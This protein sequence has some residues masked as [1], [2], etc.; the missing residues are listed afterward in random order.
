MYAVTLS[1]KL[2]PLT[3][4]Q[5]SLNIE[6]RDRQ[7]R[8]LVVHND[9]LRQVMALGPEKEEKELSVLDW[10]LVNDFSADGRTMLIEEDGDGGGPNYSVYLRKT[11]GS[12]AV[13]LGEGRRSPS[14]R[15]A[16]GL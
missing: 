7:G 6:D 12:A 2:R 4:S 10:A 5:G 1:G 14:R 15:T 3:Q 13:R 16:L 11:D 9:Y 8:L